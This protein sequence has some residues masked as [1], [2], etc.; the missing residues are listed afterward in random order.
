VAIAATPAR[1]DDFWR[2][3]A[4]A[5]MPI[6]GPAAVHGALLYNHGRGVQRDGRF[7]AGDSFHLATYP[8]IRLMLAGGWDGFRLNRRWAA[9]REDDSIAA[10]QREIQRLRAE[11]YRRI[12]LAGQSYGA[13]LSVL[14]ATREGNIHA[15]V[16][17]AP[18]TGHGT[19]SADA[20]NRNAQEL[21]D[22]ANELKRTRVAMFLF[23]GDALDAAWLK[24]GERVRHVLE[25]RGI[26]HMVVDR[27]E[28]FH[29]HSA[30]STS[31]FAL[32]YGQC[33]ARFVSPALL[34]RTTCDDLSLEEFVLRATKMD[35]KPVRDGPER[36][37]PF[38]GRWL[39]EFG[40]AVRLFVPTEIV[41]ATQ[42]RAV[43]GGAAVGASG[44]KPYSRQTVL[45]TLDA[46]RLSYRTGNVEYGFR[47][48]ADGA[49]DAEW[50]RI[51]GSG[52][53]KG[54]FRRL[55]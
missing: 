42:L 6:R 26:P 2:E 33:L 4:F 52:S 25:R 23:E 47:A 1:A 54:T 41:S 35:A 14:A 38:L 24:R 44:S 18:G 5:D 30:S 27:P 37:A 45:A 53:A 19:D 12:V 15:I 51:D 36:L 8:Y 7:V 11:G 40:E 50:R 10:L 17:T 22:Y 13:W 49:L 29:G 46:D 34:D 32:R 31:L 39:G 16:V 48:R 3:P 55:P 9:D 28:G 43:Y 21:V 20:V